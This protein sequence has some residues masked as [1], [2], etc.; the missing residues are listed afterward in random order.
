M[1]SITF[2]KVRYLKLIEQ[3]TRLGKLLWKV[4]RQQYALHLCTHQPA[5]SKMVHVEVSEVQAASHR[6]VKTKVA[7]E[8][9]AVC[10]LATNPVVLLLQ[11]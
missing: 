4:C 6:L 1:L 9:H 10:T 8:I 7:G 3:G 5:V 2:F 11:S